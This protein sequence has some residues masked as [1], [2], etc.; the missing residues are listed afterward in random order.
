MWA[1]I[2]SLTKWRGRAVSWCSYKGEMCGI[3]SSNIQTQDHIHTCACHTHTHTHISVSLST[4]FC[5]L[6]RYPGAYKW[7]IRR[8]QTK[9]TTQL[10]GSEPGRRCCIF[11]VMGKDRTVQAEGWGKREVHRQSQKWVLESSLMLA[12]SKCRIWGWNNRPWLPKRN[13]FDIKKAVCQN[14]K[15]KTSTKTPVIVQE[16]ICWQANEGIS[17]MY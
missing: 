14:H 3:T 15:L 12:Y 2:T 9:S 8:W 7:Q 16:P 17:P 11:I 5:I 4:K 6:S 1:S 13:S 10:S